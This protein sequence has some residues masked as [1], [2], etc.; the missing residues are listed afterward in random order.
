MPN[1]VLTR[2]GFMYRRSQPKDSQL[3]NT[4]RIGLS[5]F[6]GI[7]LFDIWSS[8]VSEIFALWIWDHD[9][10]SALWPYRVAFSFTTLTIFMHCIFTILLSI[11]EC[12]FIPIKD[13]DFPRCSREP[14]IFDANK[15]HWRRL[16]LS[17]DH[18]A[19][20]VVAPCRGLS[21]NGNFQ[22]VFPTAKKTRPRP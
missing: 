15:L 20:F 9:K 1:E 19:T 14:L 17:C 11:H 4:P 10:F 3:R 7:I 16:Y 21:M 2:H 12:L 5:T 18:E 6:W 22:T 8:Q 13:L